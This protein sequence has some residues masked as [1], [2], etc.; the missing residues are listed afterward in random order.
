MSSCLVED[1]CDKLFSVNTEMIKASPILEELAG[2]S[3][4][5]T[6][7]VIKSRLA[8]FATTS[9]MNSVREVKSYIFYCQKNQSYPFPVN[10]GI[11]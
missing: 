3:R 10:V 2:L 11:L 6:N 5:D 1:I 7:K 9:I 8:C 4:G